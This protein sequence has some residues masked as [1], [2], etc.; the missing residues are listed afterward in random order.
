MLTILPMFFE[1]VLTVKS[2]II[3]I[4]SNIT[5]NIIRKVINV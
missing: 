3:S 5:E 1:H 2:S 4:D